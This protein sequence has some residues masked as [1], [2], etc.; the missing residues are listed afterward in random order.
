MDLHTVLTS[1]AVGRPPEPDG[2]VDVLAQQGPA[3]AVVA[4]TAIASLYPTL[5]N[6]KVD[7]VITSP[8]TILGVPVLLL[9]LCTIYLCV[10]LALP[11]A[12]AR[13]LS[14]TLTYLVHFPA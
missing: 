7:D 4:F 1:A 2:T 8:S 14:F 12:P 6:N 10:R 13:I 9:C 3:P 11:G 5:A